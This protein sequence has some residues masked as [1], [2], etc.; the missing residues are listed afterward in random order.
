MMGYSALT[1]IQNNIEEIDNDW[2]KVDSFLKANFNRSLKSF[3]KDNTD[4]FFE[5]YPIPTGT[6]YVNFELE[7]ADEIEYMVHTRPF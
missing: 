6:H 2:F 3:L 1:F 5:N 4:L 7:R